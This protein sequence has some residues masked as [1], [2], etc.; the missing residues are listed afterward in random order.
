[1]TPEEQAQRWADYKRWHRAQ[2]ESDDID[3]VYPWLRTLADWWGLNIEQRSWLVMCHVVWY[4]PGS[5]IAAFTRCDSVRDLPAQLDSLLAMRLPTGTER[6]GHRDP[7]QLVRHL[8]ALPR[9]IPDGLWAFVA[10]HEEWPAL[11]DRLTT[12]TGNGRWAAY[13]TAEMLQKVCGFPTTATDAGH[14]YSSGPRKGLADLYGDDPAGQGEAVIAELDRRTA[15]VQQY[16]AEPD[17][18]LVETSLCDF[19]SAVKGNYY[20]GRDIDG[21]QEDL[22][23]VGSHLAV[24][25]WGEIWQ[26]RAKVFREDLLGE[27]NGWSGVRSELKRRYK[28]T[29]VI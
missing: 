6:R 3:P 16:L 20:I 29:G 13:K 23:R 21:M 28:E 19:H 25:T 12:I 7:K 11:N 15:Y 14:R 17:I 1:M 24:I 5:T 9:E 18:A 4:H 26:A 10:G 8:E 2:V 22:S 27:V